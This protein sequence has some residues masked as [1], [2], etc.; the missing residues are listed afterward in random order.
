MR[1]T[2]MGLNRWSPC[3]QVVPGIVKR[4]ISDTAAC[5]HSI[6]RISNWELLVYFIIKIKN[7]IYSQLCSSYSICT[8]QCRLKSEP[9]S[10]T[11][12]C[13]GPT[14]DQ[15][16]AGLVHS[17]GCTTRFQGLK[18][19]VKPQHSILSLKL[20]VKVIM[21]VSFSLPCLYFDRFFGVLAFVC[22]KLKPH[23]H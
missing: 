15:P 22:T 20:N 11:Q 16:N 9:R 6:A 18:Q 7:S 13:T 2:L 3:L 23:F 10:P 4:R 21:R 19:C 17:T 5:M 1:V 8:V 12:A 14:L